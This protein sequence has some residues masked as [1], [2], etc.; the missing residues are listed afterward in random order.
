M[1][2]VTVRDGIEKTLKARIPEVTG[3]R[4]VTDHASGDAPYISRG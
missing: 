4:D 3:I 2:E 1:V